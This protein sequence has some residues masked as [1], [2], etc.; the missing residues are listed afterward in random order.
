M[1]VQCTLHT[2]RGEKYIS[3]LR[4]NWSTSRDWGVDSTVI[5][6]GEERGDV[7][8]QKHAEASLTEETTT[9]SSGEFK[10]SAN[11]A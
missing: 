1:R 3:G 2:G 7:Y 5:C 11:I 8:L 6:C 4:G 10:Q 9:P